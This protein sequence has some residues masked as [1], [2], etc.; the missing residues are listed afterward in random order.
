M[1]AFNSA[2]SLGFMIGPLLGGFV[3]QT[4]LGMGVPMERAFSLAFITGGGAAA[5]VALIAIPSLVRLVR[6][7]RTT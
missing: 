7:G 4:S 5:L 3:V 1:G 2:G 6:A